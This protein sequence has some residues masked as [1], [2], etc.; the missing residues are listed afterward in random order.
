MHHLPAALTS[1]APSPY[2]PF[3]LILQNVVSAFGAFLDPVADKL[4]VAATLVLLSTR[5][6]PVGPMAGDAFF[7]PMASLGAPRPAATPPK[8]NRP[9]PP[10]LLP[11]LLLPPLLLL[12]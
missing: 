12:A 4:M 9:L 6:I 2:A 11:P 1:M 5:P 7:I 3:A 8:R 10:L